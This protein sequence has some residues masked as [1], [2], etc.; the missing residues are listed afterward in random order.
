MKRLVIEL[1][2][3]THAT[4]KSKAAADGVTMTGIIAATVADYLAGKWK[5]KTTKGGK[6]M[7]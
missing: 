2:D 6:P 1:E 7:K 4:F 5:P 3:K